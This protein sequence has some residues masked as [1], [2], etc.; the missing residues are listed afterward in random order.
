MT[1]TETMS[2]FLSRNLEILKLTI[3]DFSDQELLVRPVPGAN[4]AA[5]Q[6]G[7]L[8]QSAARM[9]NQVAPGVI[10][11]PAAKIGESFS[12][13]T[14]NVDD[15]AAYPGKTSLLEALSQSYGA[16]AQWTKTLA[17]QDL[18]RP[19]PPRMAQFAPTVGLM[20]LMM[21]GHL[22]MHV[23]QVQVIRRKLGKPLLF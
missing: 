19:T 1:Q 7:H 5:W 8:I 9:M 3:A 17:P 20:V 10:P 16:I 23:G 21:A 12:G 18:D 15:P 2:D 11:E 22:I 14:A 13:K 6:L 4:H